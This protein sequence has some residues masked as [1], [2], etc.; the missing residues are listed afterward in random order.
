MNSTHNHSFR[1][2]M[3]DDLAMLA[4]WQANPHVREW[5]D[6]EPY[7][8]ADL[9]DPRVSRWIVLSGDRPFAYMQDDV[10]P[11]A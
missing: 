1:V 7:N 5:W 2:M 4:N 10:A 6:R 11:C 9:A 8:E 3:P